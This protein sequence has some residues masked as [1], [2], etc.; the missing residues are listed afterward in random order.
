MNPRSRYRGDLFDALFRTAYDERLVHQCFQVAGYFLGQPLGLN[1]AGRG[2]RIQ[3]ICARIPVGPFPSLRCGCWSKRIPRTITISPGVRL[4]EFLKRILVQL[5]LA[6]G[7]WDRA[8]R[9]RIHNVPFPRHPPNCRIAH[10]CQPNLGVR[11]L[12]GLCGRPRL[13]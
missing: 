5:D 1:H 7:S 9:T 11:F 10:G 4:S 6:A 13:R 3:R 8:G 12:E 2:P